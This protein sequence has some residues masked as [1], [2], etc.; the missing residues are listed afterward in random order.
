MSSLATLSGVI[1]HIAVYRRGEWHL[2]SPS[3]FFF[4]LLATCIPL[5]P[6]FLPPESQISKVLLSHRYLILQSILV[7]LASVF[8][9]TF[10]YRVFFHRL[11]RFPGPFL[12]GVSSAYKVGLSIPNLHIYDEVKRLHAYYGDIVRLGPTELSLASP[13]AFKLLHYPRAPVSKGPWYDSYYPMVSLETT[14]DDAEHARRRKVWDRAFSSKALRD[15]ASRVKKYG[16]QLIS[17]IEQHKD[18][19]LDATQIFNYYSFDVMGDLAF[20]KSFRM[21]QENK[22]HYVLKTL[23]ENMAYVGYLG[24]VNWIFPFFLRTPIL[25]WEIKKFFGFIESQVEERRKLKPELPDVFS[26]ILS[27]HDSQPE[28]K[29]RKASLIAEAQLVIVAGS[30]TTAATLSNLFYELLEN[31]G[32]IHKLREELD[33]LFS[34]GEEV[35]LEQLAKAKHLNAVINETLR[36]HPAVP[37]GVQRKTPPEGLYL[38]ET[39]IPGDV[40]VQV[41][42]YTVFRDERCFVDPSSFIPERF[43]TQPE[44]VKD[45]STFHP[46]SYGAYSCVGK[47]LALAE[48]RWVT[49][50]ILISYD[51]RFAPGYRPESYL[52]NGIDAF[53]YAS[54]PLHVVFTPR[55]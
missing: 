20:G 16:N 3:V 31:P 55:L 50:M 6:S 28:T 30:D 17:M 34:T 29:A 26:W 5:L 53:T 8:W 7:H 45:S 32:Q 22:D 25:N 37:S 33:R 13:E 42:F 2:R 14:R 15:Y 11:R 1:A 51:I 49:S 39:W 47:Q 23:H 41:P 36:L 19:P 46:F 43:T 48:L 40:I 52:E 12:A 38:E 18:R 27:D 24:P 44:L 54:A 9:S 4:Y 21:L 35:H 10:I